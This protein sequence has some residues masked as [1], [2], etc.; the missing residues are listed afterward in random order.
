MRRFAAVV[1]S[2][3]VLAVVPASA[4]AAQWVG[5]GDSFAAGPLI[6]NQS[7]SP[8][9]CLRSSN[10]FARLAAASTGRH[11]DRRLVQRRAD[12]AHDAVAEHDAR[13]PTRRS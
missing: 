13:A 1:V 3:L 2:L 4:G 7:L 10:N 8:L 11:A 5:L 9:G 12:D 6:P